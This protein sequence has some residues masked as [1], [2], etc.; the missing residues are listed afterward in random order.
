M[1]GGRESITGQ[2]LVY[3]RR[4]R[5]KGN[6]NARGG[7]RGDDESTGEYVSVLRR[8][9]SHCT[10]RGSLKDLQR[11]ALTSGGITAS[12]QSSKAS[13]LAAPEARFMTTSL[14]SS[15]G[16]LE[17]TYTFALACTRRAL[18]IILTSCLIRISALVITSTKVTV[19]SLAGVPCSAR[20]LTGLALLAK[21]S[22]F[23]ALRKRHRAEASGRQRKLFRAT[24]Y[25]LVWGFVAPTGIATCDV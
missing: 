10:H 25:L 2:P 6:K 5:K 11:Q 22:Y 3:Y 7:Q 18:P 8:V 15:A 13:M 21:R 24:P 23:S 1:G 4:S 20:R 17:V 12:T 9:R 16:I 19:K 14:A